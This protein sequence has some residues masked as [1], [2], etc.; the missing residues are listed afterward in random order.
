MGYALTVQ[1]SNEETFRNL[2]RTA[3][4]LGVTVDELAEAA[5]QVAALSADLE[6]ILERISEHLE[7]YDEEDLERHIQEFAH[8]EV[9]HEDPLQARLVEATDAYGIGALFAHP[10]ERG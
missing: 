10:V 9:A 8:S 5:L 7:A 6:G 4:A 3:E 2:E 1:L